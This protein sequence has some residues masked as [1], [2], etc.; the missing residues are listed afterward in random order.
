[1]LTDDIIMAIIIFL[2]MRKGEIADLKG[3]QYC[4][5]AGASYTSV[6]TVH[7][8]ISLSGGVIGVK[9]LS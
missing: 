5:S 3:F 4:M 7:V 1:M 2:E 8:Y 6:I 9:F